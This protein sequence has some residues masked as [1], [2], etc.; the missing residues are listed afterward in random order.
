MQ[1][2]KMKLVVPKENY[3][4]NAVNHFKEQLALEG[5]HKVGDKTIEFHFDE[6]VVPAKYIKD[7]EIDADVIIS[8]GLM[9][10]L[11]KEYHNEIP[12]V[13]IPVQGIDLIRCLVNVRNR[14]GRKKVAVIGA[15]NMI[16][17]V[18][19]FEDIID[20]PINKYIMNEISESQQL[21][22]IAKDD[23]CEVVVSGLTTCE[24][25]NSLGLKSM[26]VET[27]KAS[28]NHALEEA[29]RLAIVSRK[30]QEKSKRYQT[31]LDHA[32]EGVIAI[33]LNKNI[34]MFNA[35]ALEILSVLAEDVIGK[36]INKVLRPGSLLSLLLN[37][38][39]YVEDIITYRNVQLS[40]KKIAVKL[41]GN[42]VGDMVAFQDVTGIQEIEGEIRKKIFTWSYRK[43]LF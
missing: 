3:I 35:A 18:E 19:G 28:L 8:R 37:D 39:E 2:I 36:P 27:G 38:R 14:Y 32:Y 31:I 10:K 22:H 25:A 7:T 26:I 4:K 20:L 23:G 40:I 16:F 41:K 13:D 12:V 43:T 21:V 17:G 42:K 34:S 5:K 11:I 6:V 9:S 15:M 24:Y 29:K 30:E 1:M 33:D